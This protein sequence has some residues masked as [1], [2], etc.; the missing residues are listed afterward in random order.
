MNF[1]KFDSSI[2]RMVFFIF[3]TST[4]VQV[5]PV[6]VLTSRSVSGL[7]SIALVF[8]MTSPLGQVSPVLVLTSRDLWRCN[9][10]AD[11]P[12]NTVR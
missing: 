4:Y 8:M 11:E 10:S 7:G 9:E 5:S 1:I 2:A 3:I 12:V 6:L